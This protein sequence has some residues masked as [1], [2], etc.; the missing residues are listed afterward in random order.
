MVLKTVEAE[1]MK[2]RQGDR[3][4]GKLLTERTFK[5]F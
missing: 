5:G 2:A 3:M 1:G 4:G